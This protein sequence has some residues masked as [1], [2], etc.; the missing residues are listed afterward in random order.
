VPE[1]RPPEQEA[2]LNSNV[3]HLQDWKV[4]YYHNDHLGT[5]RELSGEDG[6]IVWQARESLRKS[7]R[8]VQI[9]GGEAQRI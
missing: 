4:R 3:V 1:E 7:H 6:R 9:S 5:P 8:D 2:E